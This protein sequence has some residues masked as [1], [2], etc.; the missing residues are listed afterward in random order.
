MFGFEYPKS[1]P[2]GR[3]TLEVS[4]KPFGL[5]LSDEGLEKTCRELFDGWRELI[6]YAKSVSILMWTSDGSE[7]LQYDGCL[8]MPLEWPRYIGIGNPKKNMSERD[9]EGLNIH[10]RPYL[11]MNNP[12]RMTYRDLKRI[13]ACLKRTGQE[14]FGLT[15]EVGETFDPGPE[16]AYSEFKFH[17]HPEL[18]KGGMMSSMW[19]HCAGRLMADHYRY[20]AYP[21]GIPEGLH[22]GRFLGEQFVALRRDMGF[23]YIWL[24]NGFGFSLES[25]CWLGEVFDGTRFDTAG[26]EEV[27]SSIRTFWREFTA[28]VGDV[29]IETR[30]SNLTAG[31]DIAAHGCPVDDIYSVPNLLAPPNS[32]WAAINFRFGLELAGYMSRIAH[33]PEKGYLFRYYTHDPWWHNSPWFDR[34]DRQPHD[35]YL[36]LSVARLDE[37]GDVTPPVGIAFLSAD[38]S[39][40]RMPRRCPVE[41]TP[42][43]LD[44]YSHYP[45]A[46]GLVTWLYPFESYVQL[47]R[48]ADCV[49]DI[50]MDDWLIENAIDL[51]LPLNS[52]IADD[53]FLKADAKSWRGKILV[54]PVPHAGTPAEAALFKALDIGCCV[55]L[56]G[57]TA[58]ASEKVRALLG[59]RLEKPISGE[60]TLRTGLMHDTLPGGA[61]P[62]R[63]H[64]APLFSGGGIA[65]VS[66]GT[67]EVLA[68]VCDG[69]GENRVYAMESALPNGGRLLWMRG[70]FPHDERSR[71]DLP[72]QLDRL[73]FFPAAAMLRALLERAGVVIRFASEKR[74]Y[75]WPVLH[76]SSND[77]VRYITGY[78]GDTTVKM[79]LRFP[80]G[81][82]L[83]EGR[84][85]IVEDGLA[86]YTLEKSW[87]RRCWLYVSQQERTVVSLQ[88]RTAENPK[89]DER[90][91]VRGL[92]NAVLTV[93]PPRGADVHVIEESAR[94]ALGA[95]LWDANAANV[96]LMSS[97]DGE[98]LT[99]A[100][101]VSGDVIIVW[102]REDNPACMLDERQKHIKPYSMEQH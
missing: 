71:N 77:A 74:D 32:P 96:P 42:Y 26:A 86:V 94:Q 36:P 48:R 80:D 30:G 25:W 19:I 91:L 99:T 68:S 60:L 93:R 69:C 70:S 88:R 56:Y 43:I 84:E 44:A 78:A 7:I 95:G 45:D 37:K 52:V 63:L 61:L 12:P 10:C 18:N 34:Y 53:L 40:G 101:P 100:V 82:P 41:C 66:C 55:V 29:R 2:V 83:M 51:G 3:V 46:A 8:D 58:W 6:G 90:F 89:L 47:G 35:I 28:A 23:D 102:S 75:E 59:V 62:E 76:V 72:A 67:G 4:L 85:C 11:Y 38:D 9:P 31:M 57:S 50:F 24:S 64:H 92:K 27:R 16:F 20:A 13:I 1:M 54:T 15:V 87:N 39:Y 79:A 14:M 22:F 97:G 65:E 21:D 81:A 49:S 33:L 73:A 98:S 17:R 5:D